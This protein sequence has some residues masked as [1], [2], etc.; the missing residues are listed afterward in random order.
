MPFADSV[1]SVKDAPYNALGNGSADDAAAIQAAVDA[2]FGPASAPH[3]TSAWLNKILFFPQGQYQVHT[4]IKFT[5]VKGAMIFGAGQSAAQI[6]G[7]GCNAVDVNGMEECNWENLCVSAATDSWYVGIE[8]DWDGNT[9]NGVG[10]GGNCFTGCAFSG[11]EYNLRIGFS[12]HAGRLGAY[13]GNGG[14]HEF[15]SCSFSS[16]LRANLV[17]WGAGAIASVFGGGSSN[18]GD[19]WVIASASGTTLTVSALRHGYT[20]LGQTLIGPGL[21]TGANAVYV[22]AFGTGNTYSPVGTYTLSAPLNFSPQLVR[23]ASGIGYWAKDGQLSGIHNPGPTGNLADVQVDSA[24]TCVIKGHRS[25]SAILACSNNTGSVMTLDGCTGSSA[26]LSICQTKGIA[27]IDGGSGGQLPVL[28]TD[29]S[30]N[31]TVCLKGSLYLYQ[32]IPIGAPAAAVTVDIPSNT[33]TWPSHGNAGDQGVVFETTGTL[34]GIVPG[35]VYYA[36]AGGMTTD[37]FQLLDSPSGYGGQLVTFSGS[38]SGTHTGDNRVTAGFTGTVAE[39][40]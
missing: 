2:A 31:G 29:P 21:P 25:E 37:T 39:N 28:T 24:T 17:V 33:I 19:A 9:A 30:Y 20:Y 22:S 34:P 23:M 18:R 40:I 16:G 36:A 38:Q 10:L 15:H 12:G 5:A 8:L 3:G 7:V 13:G 14:N 35:R 27:T 26:T 32:R 6:Y 1:V 4:P 11:G